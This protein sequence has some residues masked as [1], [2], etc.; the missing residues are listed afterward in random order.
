MLCQN[1]FG[2]TRQLETN[3]DGI[4]LILSVLDFRFCQGRAVFRAPVNSLHALVNVTLLGHLAKNFHLA[5]LKLGTQGQI[6][7][8][9][10]ALHAQTLELCIH[11]INVLSGK[12]LADLAQFQLGNAGLLITQRTQCLQF[13]GKAMGIVAG[14][15]GSLETGHILITDD[16]VLDDFIQRST[17]MDAAIGI[18]RAIV[19]NVARFALVV[20]NH[21]LVDMVLFPVFQHFGF[22]F[23][24]A[25]PHFKGGLHLVD[26]VIIILRQGFLLSSI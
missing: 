23:R 8:F 15:I 14:H 11:H 17:H 4:A 7:V 3:I 9:E 13:D 6:G 1:A 10:I 18:R 2:V 24:Q 19:Q 21:L 5:G 26:G 22:L 25:G 12:F 20:A 16:D